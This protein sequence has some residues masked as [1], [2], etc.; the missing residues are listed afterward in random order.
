MMWGYMLWEETGV[1]CKIDAKMD[2]VLY[3]QILEDELQGSLKHYCL[4]INK[5]IF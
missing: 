5:I 2:K 4:E 3:T 1:G